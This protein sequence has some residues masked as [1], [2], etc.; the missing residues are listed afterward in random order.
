MDKLTESV[1]VF[2]VLNSGKARYL[3][4]LGYD[5]VVISKAMG[6][7]ESIIQAFL[8]EREPK[9]APIF[10]IED[11]EGALSESMGFPEEESVARELAQVGMPEQGRVEEYI[12][13]ICLLKLSKARV[14]PRP[15]GRGYKRELRSSFNL[16]FF[17]PERKI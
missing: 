5:P 6:I 12:E 15:L 11:Y 9:D 13:A 10:I 8:R 16:G 4:K 7:D 14:N 3:A 17:G 2:N 1:T